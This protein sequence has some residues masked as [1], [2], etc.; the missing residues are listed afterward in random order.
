[1]YHGFI[2][3]LAGAFFNKFYI[4]NQVHRLINFIPFPNL[5]TENLL[6]KRMSYADINDL[7]EKR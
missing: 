5:E 1:M 3:V 4:R 2:V 7:F 6:L